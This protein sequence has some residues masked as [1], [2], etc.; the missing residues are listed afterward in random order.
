MYARG[1]PYRSIAAL[2][3]LGSLLAWR[4]FGDNTYLCACGGYAGRATRGS[5]G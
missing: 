4:A 3:F 1:E 5:S 2:E